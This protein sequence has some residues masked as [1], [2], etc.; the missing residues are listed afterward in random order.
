MSTKTIEQDLLELEL[1]YWQAL[2]DNDVDA[3]LRLTD[4]PCIVTG[5]QGVASLEK[6]AL[7]AMMR[8]ATYQL[9]E[10]DLSDVQV[11]LVTDEV[12]LMA[13]KV[14]ERLIVAGEPVAL[15]AA[16]SSVWVRR[17]DRWVCAMHTEA[18]AGDPFG[19]DR[20]EPVE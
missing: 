20:E 17:E 7:G 3:A 14:H 10:Y 5:S 18:I 16:D 4:D 8:A 6:R 2:K 1:Q 11:R 19:R 13:Y 12:A 15:D 9:Q